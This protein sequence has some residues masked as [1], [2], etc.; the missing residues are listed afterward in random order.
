MFQQG[1]Q[2][3]Q[4]KLKI[5]HNEKKNTEVDVEDINAET[6]RMLIENIHETFFNERKVYCRGLLAMV[7][8]IKD[9]SPAAG[10][11]SHVD[12]KT[13]AS[14]SPSKTLAASSS[15]PQT[16]AKTGPYAIPGLSQEEIIKQAKKSKEKKK[17]EEKKKEAE[18][19][20]FESQKERKE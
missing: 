13:A 5:T 11:D 18:Q 6:C 12:V 7:S 16:P 19:N 3:T 15:P 10:K 1:L 9:P 8:P 20:S 17:K 4:G 14:S 2:F